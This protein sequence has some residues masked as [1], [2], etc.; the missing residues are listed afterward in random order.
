MAQTQS[1]PGDFLPRETRRRLESLRGTS[2]AAQSE[3]IPTG[4]ETV[5]GRVGGS[6]PGGVLAFAGEV[7]TE[8][9]RIFWKNNP[10]TGPADRA[11]RARKS[12]R[13]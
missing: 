11:L 4:F 13:T 8:C 2:A 6:K 7:N 5:G 1:D 12:S 3:G 10:T 9:Y